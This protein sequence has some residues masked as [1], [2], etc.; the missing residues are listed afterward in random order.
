[1]YPIP[2]REDGLLGNPLTHRKFIGT[3][4]ESLKEYQARIEQLMT[5]SITAQQ[6]SPRVFLYPQGDMGQYTLDTDLETLEVLR[7]TAAQHFDLSIIADE[8]GYVA[9]SG[10]PHLL[11]ARHVPPHWDSTHLLEHLHQ[12]H[13]VI[14]GTLQLAKVLYW[15]RQHEKANQAFQQALDLGANAEDVHYHWGANGLQQGDLPSALNHLQAAIDL[16]T[17]E[18]RYATT[19]KRAHRKTQPE[20]EIR[21][22][23][24]TDSE[25]RS[26]QSYG[27]KLFTHIYNRLAVQ[28]FLDHHNWERDG[29]GDEY[30]EKYGLGLTLYPLMQTWIRADVWRFDFSTEGLDDMYGGSASVRLPLT[31]LSGHLNLIY[32][33]DQVETVE[34]VREEIREDQYAI[35]AYFRMLDEFDIY[36]N[37]IYSELNDGNEITA[38]DGRAVWRAKEW[39]FL[40]LGYLFRFGDSD[41]DPFEYYA[42]EN[43]EQHQGYLSIRGAH[44]RLHY[45]LSARA[46]YNREE[47]ADWRFI[48]G[49][50][51]L[52]EARITEHLK[53]YGDG[54]YQESDTYDRNSIHFGVKGSL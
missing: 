18:V 1:M 27:G 37:G 28:G 21:G 29:L 15:N 52:L 26:F 2:I 8:K 10:S 16:N 17:N 12:T 47:D 6:P 35:Q 39:P 5:N 31:W 23:Y 24:T 40:G 51:G 11:P 46:G 38:V 53:V 9:D 4:K 22:T 13:P 44:R 7:K 14:S 41:F 36:L 20:I 43:L 54:V 49:L 3:T 45:A 42:P 19:M 33:H 50:R 25:D 32:R 48:W 34:A 30:G